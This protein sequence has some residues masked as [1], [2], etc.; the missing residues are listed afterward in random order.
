MITKNKLPIDRR[1]EATFVQ[2]TLSL[3]IYVI[4][5][6]VIITGFVVIMD[7]PVIKMI[8]DGFIDGVF[9][10]PANFATQ[11]IDEDLRCRITFNLTGALT[12][13][14][15][16]NVIKGASYATVL[17]PTESRH[18]ITSV[19]IMMDKVDI[20]AA[21]YDPDLNLVFIPAITGDIVITALG[22]SG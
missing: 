20:T 9:S 8:N 3:V 21:A 5:A 7:K 4:V 1:G 10:E 6:S 12:Q 2:M 18:I 16:L 13:N 14:T 11:N 15:S 19:S 22:I 17:Y